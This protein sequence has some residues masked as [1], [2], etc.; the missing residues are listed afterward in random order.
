MQ[1]IHLGIG[2]VEGLVTA[3]VVTFIYKAR[4]DFINSTEPVQTPA[5]T[6]KQVVVTLLTVAIFTGGFLSWFASEHP[7]GL[8]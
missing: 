7:D 1:P 6:M 2:I 8:E 4:P 5:L 3:A